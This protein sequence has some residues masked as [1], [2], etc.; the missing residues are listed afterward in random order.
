MV[1]VPRKSFLYTKGVPLEKPDKNKPNPK[2]DDDVLPLTIGDSIIRTIHTIAHENVPKADR[3]AAMWP[4]QIIE[5][6]EA[7]E[8]ANE[9]IN[10]VETIMDLTED[11]SCLSLA[12]IN[13]FGCLCSNKVYGLVKRKSTD[14]MQW[15]LFVYGGEID[16]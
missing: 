1:G 10:R 5:K 12:A 4:C 16:V 6:A 13:A 14:L 2:M 9:A 15:H 11:V 8:F 3:D 7:A